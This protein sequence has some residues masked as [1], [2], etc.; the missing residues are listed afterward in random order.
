MIKSALR[1]CQLPE[2]RCMDSYYLGL[3]MTI[4]LP[5]LSSIGI[6]NCFPVASSAMSSHLISCGLWVCRLHA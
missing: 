1:Q 3:M 5:A 6:T 4:C 2:T